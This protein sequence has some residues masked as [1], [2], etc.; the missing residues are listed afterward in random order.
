MNTTLS[1]GELQF[2]LVIYHAYT[3]LLEHDAAKDKKVEAFLKHHNAESCGLN[4]FGG[5][6]VRENLMAH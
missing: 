3:G 2:Y 6:P 5:A 1:V 4:A